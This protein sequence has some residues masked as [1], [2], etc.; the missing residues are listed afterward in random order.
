MVTPKKLLLRLL[1]CLLFLVALVGAVNAEVIS[2]SNL[3]ATFTNCSAINWD[4]DNSTSGDAE[5]LQIWQNDVFL[6]NVSLTQLYDNWT[7]L[8]GATGYTFSSHTC[9]VTTSCNTTWVNATSTTDS[10]PVPTPTSH[11][12]GL[13]AGGTTIVSALT[14]TGIGLIA[15]GAIMLIK[16][17]GSGNMMGRGASS[18][19]NDITTITV[20]GTVAIATGSMFLL[21][22]YVILAPIFTVVGL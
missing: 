13:S 7:G 9:N 2:I 21:I 4:Y 19:D 1:L 14:L 6:H 5:L 16:L 22:A 11:L 10:C 15:T 8:S 17:F 20:V 3:S 12:T 18:N